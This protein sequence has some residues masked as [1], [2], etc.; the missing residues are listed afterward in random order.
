MSLIVCSQLFWADSGT[1][2]V[3]KS[4]LAGRMRSV[5]VNNADGLG[6]PTAVTVDGNR[7]Y[8]LDATRGRLESVL[9][10]GSDRRIVWSHDKVEDLVA[11]DVYKVYI[12]VLIVN[13][14]ECF[15]YPIVSGWM[16]N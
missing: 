9:I 7:V 12:V 3:E 8:W 2:L 13:I 4:D 16:S 6:R 5:L 11:F 1:G 10:D 15:R 14:C